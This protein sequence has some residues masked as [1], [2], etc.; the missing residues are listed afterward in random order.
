MIFQFGTIAEPP[1]L[2]QLRGGGGLGSGIGAFITLFV[3]LVILVAGLYAFINFLLAG[4]GF[5]SAGNDPKKIQ[6]AW[7]KIWQSI[8]GLTVTAGALVIAAIVGYL[9]FNDARAILVPT[10][11]T[12]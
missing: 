4:Y 3:Q 8:L 12:L 5:L 2:T 9:V 6:E 10:I 11:P 1:E 7:T